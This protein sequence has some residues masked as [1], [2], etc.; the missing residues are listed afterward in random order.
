[1]FKFFFLDS[2]LTAENV[3]E[4]L[5]QLAENIVTGL[6]AVFRRKQ[7]V[8]LAWQLLG[9]RHEVA[10]DLHGLQAFVFKAWTAWLNFFVVQ[11]VRDA[12]LHRKQKERFHQRSYLHVDKDVGI[13]DE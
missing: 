13:T 8:V 2:L 10:A 3:A 12:E 11:Q 9:I 7:M 6:G 4:R 1:M 5:E